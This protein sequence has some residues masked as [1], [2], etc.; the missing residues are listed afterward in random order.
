MA[1]V[2][3]ACSQPRDPATVD[4]VALLPVADTTSARTASPDSVDVI[5]DPAATIILR[6]DT[7][8]LEFPRVL[9]NFCE[10][11]A[12]SF[13]YSLVACTTLPL[14]S[15]DSSGAPE[16][17]RI[18]A[19]DTV[20]VET[21]NVH[22]R[23]PGLAVV[24]RPHVVSFEAAYY[25]TGISSEDSLQLAAGDSLFLLEYHGEGYWAVGH[26]GRWMI[27]QEFW[28]GP[29]KAGSDGWDNQ[30]AAISVQA[31][32]VV[33]WLRLRSPRNTGWWREEPRTSGATIRPD[34]GEKCGPKR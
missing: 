28:A 33:Q 17:G 29:V 6:S 24:R 26:K 31:P 22:V 23:A 13:N 14:Q 4:S 2:V 34:W 7:G 25:A 27:V 12:C 15:A 32:D 10:G 8:R 9:R 19:G 21:G 18:A 1:A 5:P 20:L 16:I 3:G 30:R 11:E